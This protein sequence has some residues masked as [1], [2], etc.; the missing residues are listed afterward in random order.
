[1]CLTLIVCSA[2][3]SGCGVEIGGI[4]GMTVDDAGRP[5]A[6]VQMCEGH[7]DGATLYLSRDDNETEHFGRWEVS[8]PVTGFSQFDLAAGGNGWRLVGTLK[9]RD[10]ATRY[11]IYGW[12][13]D[14]SRSA[15]HL[16]F[17]EQDLK[18]LRP[19]TVLAPSVDD[20]DTLEPHSLADFRTKICE[21]WF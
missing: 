9:P 10:P 20:F 16:E 19:G 14:S 6:V 17:S 11:M 12:S 15:A 2:T 18:G 21:N 7:I 4:V 1:M 3:L 13:N 8:P 5:V